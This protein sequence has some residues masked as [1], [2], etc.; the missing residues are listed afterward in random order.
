MTSIN[1]FSPHGFKALG[2]L[3][4][5]GGSAFTGFLGVDA[6]LLESTTTL[7]DNWDNVEALDSTHPFNLAEY[8]ASD[9]TRRL[10]LSNV[11][12]TVDGANV[13]LSATAPTWTSL[14]LGDSGDD[15]THI[16]F[17]VRLL[18]AAVD[19][20]LTDRIPLYIGDLAYSPGGSDLPVTFPSMGP[21]VL[22][23]NGC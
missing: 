17:Y 12:W 23:T 19:P 18:D 8:E 2:D 16:L 1:R 15:I 6:M 22:K 5:S 21:F 13:Y 4:T 11:A 9:S 3:I 20:A 10:T 7:P 14:V